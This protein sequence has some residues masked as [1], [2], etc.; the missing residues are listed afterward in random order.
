MYIIVSLIK[1]STLEL[2]GHTLL[3]ETLQGRSSHFLNLKNE[4]IP[5][6]NQ[7]PTLES[8]HVVLGARRQMARA[9]QLGERWKLLHFGHTRD[10]R[11]RVTSRHLPITHHPSTPFRP[12]HPSRFTRMGSIRPHSFGSSPWGWDQFCTA[13]LCIVHGSLCLI[14]QYTNKDLILYTSV[15][16]TCSS[17][18]NDLRGTVGMLPLPLCNLLEESFQ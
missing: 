1:R 10:I 6:S 8:A 5:R 17:P 16:I 4:K 12:T 2:E 11:H 14:R 9:L 18:A 3:G 15:R 7:V 13:L